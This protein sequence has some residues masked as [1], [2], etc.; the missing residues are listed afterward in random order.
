VLS[1]PW[2]TVAPHPLRS[3]RRLVYLIMLP[4]TRH[5]TGIRQQGLGRRL[6]DGPPALAVGCSVIF[7]LLMGKPCERSGNN[8]LDGAKEGRVVSG[9][10]ER[11]LLAVV[12]A[13]RRR[14]H[15]RRRRKDTQQPNTTLSIQH[16]SRLSRS[17]LS[18]AS[19]SPRRVGRRRSHGGC[20]RPRWRRRKVGYI[21]IQYFQYKLLDGSECIPIHWISY[22]HPPTVSDIILA[23]CVKITF[24]G[25]SKP[26]SR[27]C[28]Q[29]KTLNPL[30][31]NRSA[32]TAVSLCG[33]ATL[34]PKT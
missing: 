11:S 3:P 5:G 2:R 14:R 12:L 29:S 10:R 4:P 16:L 23:S 1:R 15:R 21:L 31:S 33:S 19:C 18:L 9:E 25:P 24:S 32:K 27:N 34:H 7:R 22:A 30:N 28:Q 6:L 26:V 8:V 20:I 13:A 17:L